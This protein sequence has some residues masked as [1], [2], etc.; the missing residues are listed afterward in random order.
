MIYFCKGLLGAP[1]RATPTKFVEDV[2]WAK[3]P[4]GRRQNVRAH[5]ENFA[6]ASMRRLVAWAAMIH[7][8]FDLETAL[9]VR[10]FSS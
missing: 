9:L 7:L 5:R 6:S 2:F 1:V 8:H 4:Q 3:E 10:V